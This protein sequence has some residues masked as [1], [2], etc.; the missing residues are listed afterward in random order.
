MMTA[1]GLQLAAYSPDKDEFRNPGDA[2]S[3]S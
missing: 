2:T 1:D 3:D